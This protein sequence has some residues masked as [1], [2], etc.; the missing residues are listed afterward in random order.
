MDSSMQVD[1][2]ST[3]SGNRKRSARHDSDDE[4]PV[5]DDQLD[6]PSK[7]LRNSKGDAI[8]RRTLKYNAQ[9]LLNNLAFTQLYV[10]AN[11]QKYNPGLSP[12][13]LCIVSEHDLL[14]R[15][16]C[17][18]L[19]ALY[20]VAPNLQALAVVT[21]MPEHPVGPT[22]ELAR[23]MPATTLSGLQE[24]TVDQLQH[25]ARALP[26]PTDSI[27]VIDPSGTCVWTSDELEVD[28]SCPVRGAAWLR[29]D[30]ERALVRVLNAFAQPELMDEG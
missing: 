13:V 27:V 7:R 23:V 10:T 15:A 6:T 18:V 2:V 8:L 11:F 1:A 3:L 19:P 20:G 24:D 14:Y 26:G 28:D 16:L 4:Q 17:Q 22:Q 12:I 9:A 25:F 5:A 21:G 29:S 30:L